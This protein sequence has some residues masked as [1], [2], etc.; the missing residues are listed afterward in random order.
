[1]K[2]ISKYFLG[3]SLM[4][5][6]GFSSC[7]GDLDVPPKDPNQDTPEKM[8]AQDPRGTM[9]RLLAE[10]YQ[11]LA[12]SSNTDPGKS[13]LGFGDAGAGTFTRTVFNLEELTTDHFSWLQFS[14]A[15]YYELVT[16]A[17]ASDNEVMYAAYSRIYGE[18]ALCNEFIRTIEK[19]RSYLSDSDQAAADDAIRQAKILRSYA[20][21]Y[22]ISDFGNAGYVDETTEAGTAPEQ[23]TRA[24][25]YNTVVST[26]EAVSAEYGDNYA[27]PAYGYVGK[28]VADALLARFYLNAGVFTGTPAYDKCWNICQKIIAHHQGAGFDNSGLADSYKALFGANNH[29]Y[30]AQGSRVNEIIFTVPQDGTNLKSY[31]G[32]TFYIAACCG[33][34]D[35]ISSFNDCNLNAQW[36]CMVAREQLANTF[37]FTTDGYTDDL[38]AE[39]WKTE[40][41]GF[42][43]GNSTIMGNAGFAKGYAPLKYTN[44]AYD[45]FG[46]IDS[47]KSPKGSEFAFADAD[48]AVI[49][50]AE[51]YLN[52]VEANVVGNVGN[53]ADALKYINYIRNRA[54][55][56]ELG[57]ASLTAENI[58]AERSR[59]LYGEN[60]RR[61]DLVRFGKFAGGGYVWNWKGGVHDGRD[62]DAH[63]NLYPIP[64]KVIAF[65]KYK[66]NDGYS[67]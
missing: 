17:F 62:V 32:S 10:C 21:F 49:R 18:I 3:L 54:G 16:T 8:F 22:A 35:G 47:E 44:Y 28:E 39:L 20:Y 51:V 42:E 19:Y 55:V 30:A 45:E 60:L 11:G 58:L 38:R 5:A 14:D 36:T 67:N 52:A 31:A 66:Q 26:L 56:A 41:D 53:Q 27:A 6:A 34:A 43:R 65:Q 23:Y 25:L 61:T 1:M 29:E 2:Y 37:G 7:V 40:K 63:F 64:S 57:V 46:N 12:T 15:G 50:L 4:L 48:W 24:E 59:E 9:D 33:S 13:I